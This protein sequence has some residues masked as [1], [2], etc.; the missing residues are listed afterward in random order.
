M[1]GEYFRISEVILSG[2]ADFSNTRILI[3]CLFLSF[4]HY[5]QRIITS[6]VNILNIGMVFVV[7]DNRL[8]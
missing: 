1:L 8:N 7:M 4:Q 5:K 3:F 2:P 6:S